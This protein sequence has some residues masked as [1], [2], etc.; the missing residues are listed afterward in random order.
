[1]YRKLAPIKAAL[2]S[3]M[4]RWSKPDFILHSGAKNTVPFHALQ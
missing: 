1:M 3:C 4:E 2:L